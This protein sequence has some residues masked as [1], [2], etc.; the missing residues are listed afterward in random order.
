ML[1]RVAAPTCL[2]LV[3]VALPARPVVGAGTPPDAFWEALRLECGRA[4]AGT[5]V[6][7][8]PSTANDPFAGQA[9]TMQ[10]R[11]CTED[12]V[13]IPLHV[14]ADRSRTWVV[15]RS[16]T[17]LK[18]EH[19]HRHEDGSPDELT[20]YGGTTL[21]PGTAG[22]QEFPADEYSRALFQR[23]GRA[24]S[25]DNVW[26]IEVVPGR[27]LAY[28][29]TRPGR[30]FRIEFDLSRPVPAPPAPWGEAATRQDASV[31]R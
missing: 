14:G 23:T 1:R 3:V 9:L 24:V 11:Q 27:M 26:A 12:Q 4:Y 6:A 31:T 20:L 21:T 25:M 19:D 30:R 10:V 18:L 17:G 8:E 5:L 22:R 16:G 13:R 15:T 2:L 7:N 29:L 28:E